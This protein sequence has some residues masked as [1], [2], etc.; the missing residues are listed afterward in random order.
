VAEAAVEAREETTALVEGEV[1]HIE[2]EKEVEEAEEVV[3]VAIGAIVVIG[4]EEEG[5][6]GA[7][8]AIEEAFFCSTIGQWSRCA[9]QWAALESPSL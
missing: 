2:V 3:I 5:E 1:I 9:S 7:I 4:D 8:E 6:D